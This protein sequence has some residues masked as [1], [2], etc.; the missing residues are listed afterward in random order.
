MPVEKFSFL[1]IIEPLNHYPLESLKLIQDFLIENPLFIDLRS[2]VTP[3]SAFLPA[4]DSGMT[5]GVS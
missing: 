5:A 3:P 1:Y 4:E 2:Y